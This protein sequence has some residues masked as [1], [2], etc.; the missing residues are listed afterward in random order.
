MYIGEKL[1][2]EY[3][4]MNLVASMPNFLRDILGLI[5]DLS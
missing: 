2:D 3:K 5:F 4:L 1:L